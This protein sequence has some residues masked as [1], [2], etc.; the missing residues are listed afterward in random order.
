MRRSVRALKTSFFEPI[1]FCTIARERARARRI[2]VCAFVARD[3]RIRKKTDAAV[4]RVRER[5]RRKKA[6]GMNLAKFLP[7]YPLLDERDVTSAT[8]AYYAQSFGTVVSNKREF[9]RL[10]LTVDEALP[11]GGAGQL[12]LHQTYLPRFVSTRTGYDELLLMHEM[13]TGKTCTAVACVEAMRAEPDTFV[14]RALIVA[15]NATILRNFVRELVFVCTDGTY[16]PPDYDRLSVETRKTRIRRN[17]GSFYTTLTFQ[18]LARILRGKSD[19]AIAAQYSDTAIV[20][21]EVQNLRA[22]VENDA[23]DPDEPQPAGGGASS[24]MMTYPELYE[25][26]SRLFRLTRRRKILLLSGTPMTDSVDEFA[27]VMNLLLPADRQLPTGRQF[28]DRYIDR[29]TGAFNDAAR[30]DFTHR[31]RGRVSYLRASPADVSSRY[32]GRVVRPQLA[33]FVV[34]ELAMSAFQS[35]HYAEAYRVDVESQ[36][37]YSCSRQA[38]LFVYPDGSYGSTGFERYVR[39]TNYDNYALSPELYAALNGDG[40]E[41]DRL[42][43]LQRFSC[44]YATVVR[45]MIAGNYTPTFVYSQYVRGSGT[46][47]FACIIRQLFG[48]ESAYGKERVKARRFALLTSAT[49][50]DAQTRAVL[51]RFNA[52]DNVDGEYISLIVGSRLVSEGIT[53]RHVRREFILTPHWNY[54]ETSQV[55][56]RCVRKGALDDVRRRYPAAAADGKVVV[57]IHQVVAVPVDSRTTNIDLMIYATAETKDVAIRRVERVIKESAFDCALTLA[58]N[59][60]RASIDGSRDCDYGSCRYACDAPM[61]ADSNSTD[62]PS[63]FDL[64]YSRP[65]I[66]T[67]RVESYLRRAFVNGIGADERV[68]FCVPTRV[69]RDAFASAATS[70]DSLDDFQIDRIVAEL[71]ASDTIFYDRYGM[72]RLLRSRGNSLCLARDDGDDGRFNVVA[73]ATDDEA[74]GGGDFYARYAPVERRDATFEQVVRQQYEDD[75]LRQLPATF[76]SDD[77]DTTSFVASLVTLPRIVQLIALR[78]AVVST[79]TDRPLPSPGV[80]AKRAAVLKTF[81]SSY[82]LDPPTVW[83]YDD[84]F[85]S[86]CYDAT[87]N[88]EWVE[89]VVDETTRRA[90]QTPRTIS[91]IGIY[92]QINPSTDKFCIRK[93]DVA[94]A[95]AAAGGGKIDRRRINVGR[96]CENWDKDELIDIVVN[97]MRVDGDEVAARALGTPREAR[98]RLEELLLAI[99]TRRASGSKSQRAAGKIDLT[100]DMDDD[101]TVRRAVFWMGQTVSALCL[102]IRAW[103]EERDLISV[104]LNCGQSQKRR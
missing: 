31:I 85:A 32:V 60:R 44:K 74:H 68:T 1:I 75:L 88:G 7:K 82:S 81:A 90:A 47:L 45:A 94:A 16:V 23:P 71:I 78:T 5:P 83:L 69:V 30:A 56:A 18:R 29:S 66:D 15:K 22:N 64:Y 53:I 76:S 3:R 104:D 99:R 38:N 8:D 21:D 93:E 42:D 65:T 25:Q 61:T 72:A 95:A 43:R 57:R 102:T 63:T 103:L 48:F 50:S 13:G 40:S 27:A 59:E 97:R 9:R 49:S 70:A 79:V 12:L 55:I 24:S 51:D 54:A 17:V 96:L 52:P 37:I 98:R 58:R 67:A 36:T 26:F 35:E 92:G 28:I 91:P 34:D 73:A 6:V 41:R 86:T 11:T 46:I 2:F 14:K 39:G 80:E 89:C 77:I 19:Q 84:E 4:K 100:F 20:V 62:D 87:G 33:Q 101:A 10:M